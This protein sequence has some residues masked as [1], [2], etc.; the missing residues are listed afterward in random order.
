MRQGVPSVS[1][2]AAQRLRDLSSATDITGAAVAPLALIDWPWP[3]PFSRRLL[4]LPRAS[5]R[6]P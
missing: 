5:R 6:Q 1:L 3:Q 4:N 2:L